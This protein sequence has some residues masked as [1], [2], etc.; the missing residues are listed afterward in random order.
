MLREVNPLLQ[1]RVPSTFI[2]PTSTTRIVT[3]LLIPRAESGLYGV[4]AIELGV[5]LTP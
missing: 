3:R 1:P 2:V 4:A 5:P